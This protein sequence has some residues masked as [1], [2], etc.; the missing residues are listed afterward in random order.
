M[1]ALAKG[2]AICGW[3]NNHANEMVAT[4]VSCFAATLSRV[5]KTARPFSF[6]YALALPPLTLLFRSSSVLYFPVK[7]PEAKDQ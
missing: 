4:L 1:V 3:A 7:K 2:A 6:K 5:A